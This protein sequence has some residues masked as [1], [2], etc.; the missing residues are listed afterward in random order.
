MDKKF[1]IILAWLFSI[2]V[3]AQEIIPKGY[4][5]KDSV[6]IGEPLPFS[7]SVRYN[8]NLD[9][10]FPDSLYDFSPFELDKRNYFFTRSDSV[11]SFDS[12]VY[13]FSTFEIDTVQSLTLPVFIIN[14]FDSTIFYTEKDSIILD[15]VVVAM[16]DSVAMLVNTNYQDLPLAFNYPYFTAGTVIIIIIIIVIYIVFGK[17]IRKA[18]RIYWMNKRHSR[19]IKLFEEKT[20]TGSIEVEATLAFWKK[21]L[22]KLLVKPYTKFTS[23]EIVIRDNDPELASNLN[24]IDRNIYGGLQSSHTIEAFDYLK[25]YAID[26]YIRK[27]EAIKN[28]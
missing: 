5:L 9:I 27:K 28:G 8:K 16:P 20:T 10:A 19:F 7:L 6:K 2:P 25:N 11:E 23:K 21:Y 18:I 24:I 1:L 14:E 13:Y 26:C 22:E 12:A 17:G 15:Q 3:F 4:F